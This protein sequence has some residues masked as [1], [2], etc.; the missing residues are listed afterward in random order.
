[1]SFVKKKQVYGLEGDIDNLHFGGNVFKRNTLLDNSNPSSGQASLNNTSADDVTE[2]RIHTN[3]SLIGNSYFFLNELIEG[4]KLVIKSGNNQFSIYT[5]NSISSEID[6][7]S[8]EGYFILILQHSF[9]YASSLASGELVFY[10]RKS[11]S[12]EIEN[13]TGDLTNN[14]ALITAETANRKANDLAETIARANAD[15]DLQNQ[16]TALQ[17]SKFTD[18]IALNSSSAT[19]VTH[20]LGTT[21]VIVQLKNNEGSMVNDATVNNY[22]DNSVD[23]QTTTN[24]TFRVIILS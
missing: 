3:D 7:N 14:L 10:I 22:Q 15:T 4:D 18:D 12:A 24:E 17:N 5:I 1:M 16:I 2:V 11:I 21:D 9:G 6:T 23:I 19:T 8:N 13:T 20:G